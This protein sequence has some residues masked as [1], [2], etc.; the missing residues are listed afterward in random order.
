MKDLGG[1]DVEL[2]YEAM[3]HSAEEERRGLAAYKALG[4]IPA[5]VEPESVSKTLE[6]AYDDWCV[7]QV[8]RKLGRQADAER[9]ARRSQGYKHLFD[10]ATGFMR[11]RL[12]GSWFTPFDPAEVN[13]NYTEANA[14]QY[15]FFVP[16]DVDG[17]MRLHGGREGLAAKLD[18][19]FGAES[20]L[21]GNRQAD[22][23]GLVGQYA[24]GNEPS[25]HMAYLYAFAGEPWKTQSLVRRLLDTMYSDRPDG[26]AGN[27]DC[28]QMSAWYVLSALGFYPVTPGSNQYVIGSPLFDR[29][30]VALEGGR[31]FVVSAAGASAGRQYVR[32]VT[33]NGRPHRK[34]YLE[35]AEIAAGGELRFVMG[36]SPDRAWGAGA[37]DAPRTA[38]GGSMVVPT[39]FVAEGEPVF[40]GSTRVRVSTAGAGDEIRFTLD[41]TTPTAASP[42]FHEPIA[43]SADTTL[44]A[45]ALGAGGAR[46]PVLTAS[47]HRIPDGRSVRLDGPYL[48]QYN[49]GGESALVDGLRA[50]PNYRLGR[51][52]GFQG[53]DLEAVV[54]LGEA[55]EVRRLAVGFLQDTGVWIFM[56]RSVE[57]AVSED[58]SAFEDAGT[59][60]NAVP[61]TDGSPAVHELAVEVA[62]RRARFVRVRV[63]QYGPLPAWHPG[64][65]EPSIFF[66]DE[67]VA[68]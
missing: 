17:L 5:D 23:T 63:R 55:R 52:Q 47:F 29:A 56:P 44:K 35:H 39:P 10:P 32:A 12:E 24:H 54:D 16:H 19:L 1:F 46:S 57:F 62:P 67:I 4:Y 20:A 49:G 27:E 61:D 53:R 41:G 22:I 11:A 48:R 7:A 18:A 58:G 43:V 6:Y 40:R 66:A 36:A 68:E 8:A 28:G 59:A 33:L 25:H 31:R 51:W 34:A 14:W 42:L 37:G 13:F 64:A 38:A 21:K 30:T 9:Y 15:S 45:V 65:G 3:K 2:A 50:G 26:L 60:V